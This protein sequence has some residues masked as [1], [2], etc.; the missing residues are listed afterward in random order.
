MY[1]KKNN[2]EVI[3]RV[4]SLDTNFNEALIET[5]LQLE[6]FLK[7]AQFPSHGVIIKDTK[8]HPKT[9]IKGIDNWTD[10]ELHYTNFANENRSFYIETDMRAMYNPTRMKVIEE[11]CLKLIKKAQT[12]CPS[13]DFP[14]FGIVRAEEGLPCEWCSNKTRSTLAFV[15]ECKRCNYSERD[16]FPHGKRTEDPMYCDFCNP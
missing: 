13:C 7:K 2:I 1:D 8:D 6:D 16:Y 12:V 4:L 11:A 9:I 15:Y 3:E 14:G 10:L 5:R